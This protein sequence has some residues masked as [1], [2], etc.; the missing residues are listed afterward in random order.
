MRA[1]NCCCLQ[2]ILQVLLACRRP[3]L[4]QSCRS[5]FC[6]DESR[7]IPGWLFGAGQVVFQSDEMPLCPGAKASLLEAS[8]VRFAALAFR[9]DSCV[10]LEPCHAG[11][12]LWR[13]FHRQDQ[14]AYA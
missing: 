13:G 14:P 5:D 3:A 6:Y 8:L 7:E 1:G 4:A 2:C 12:A 10:H 9:S 11:N